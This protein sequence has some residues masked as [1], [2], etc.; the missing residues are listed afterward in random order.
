MRPQ[1]AKEERS[2]YVAN[3]NETE[4]AQ[5]QL[6]AIKTVLD[7]VLAV[8]DEA[9]DTWLVKDAG[10]FE[11]DGTGAD[12]IEEDFDDADRAVK[13]FLSLKDRTVRSPL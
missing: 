10:V 7:M 5:K 13:Y 3:T 1:G 8:A 11:V 6:D 9:L 4:V 2:Q 12:P